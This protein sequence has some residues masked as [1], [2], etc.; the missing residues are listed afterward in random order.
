MACNSFGVMRNLIIL[1]ITGSLLYSPARAEVLYVRPDNGPPTAQYR[2]HDEVIRDPISVKTAIAVAKLAN[3]SRPIE[4]RLLRQEGAD[5]T[6][7]SV[8]L[9]TYRS[10]LRWNGSADNKLIVRGQIDRTGTFPRASTIVV[11][12]PLSK[13]ITPGTLAL[14]RA[15][16]G[17]LSSSFLAPQT[18]QTRD[19]VDRAKV[20][21]RVPRAS[22]LESDHSGGAISACGL[23]SK[24]R[25][26]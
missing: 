26:C 23:S 10:A 17:R 11:G 20:S 4:V 3:G 16:I 1:A 8:D 7:Y 15:C 18:L 21:Q 9:S 25:S 12:Q 2:W 5:E 6:F 14:G 13:T 19:E 24:S 22:S